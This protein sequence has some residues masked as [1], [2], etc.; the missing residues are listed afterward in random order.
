[1]YHKSS[2]PGATPFNTESAINHYV[3][4]G[5]IQPSKIVL[6]LPLYGRAFVDTDGP[7][8]PFRGGVGE[9]SWEK[10]VWD[11]KVLPQPGAKEVVDDEAGASYSIDEAKRVVVSYD[12]PEIAKRKAEYITKK[13]LAGAMWWESSGDAP[14]DHDRGL[15]STVSRG[16]SLGSMKHKH[17][18]Q[19][20]THCTLPKPF[21]LLISIWQS[22]TPFLG[23]PFPQHHLP[24]NPILCP[25]LISS[26]HPHPHPQQ[27]YPSHS[28]LPF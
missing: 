28:H 24:S 11:Y 4:V 7:G 9:G 13:G 18:F 16:P 6:G 19:I 25:H 10:G 22:F 3:Q 20:H 14:A 21:Q 12:N 23:S 26:P 5:R 8:T 17:R 27:K 1:M 15:I 2:K